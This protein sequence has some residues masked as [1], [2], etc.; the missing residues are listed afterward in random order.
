MRRRPSRRLAPVAL[1]DTRDLRPPTRREAHQ[2]RRRIIDLAGRRI[3]R[4]LPRQHLVTI[5]EGAVG[6]PTIIVI[7]IVIVGSE[8]TRGKRIQITLLAF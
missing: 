3:I 1:R 8:R 6:I 7:A 4:G 5:I 2:N